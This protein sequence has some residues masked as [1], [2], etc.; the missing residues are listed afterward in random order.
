[1]ELLTWHFHLR[2]KA[3]LVFLVKFGNFKEWKLNLRGAIFFCRFP[4]SLLDVPDFPWC[5][6]QVSHSLSYKVLIQ[7]FGYSWDKSG[8]AGDLN[9][10]LCMAR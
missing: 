4:K 6:L 9:A 5:E 8:S 7:Y 2:Q 10:R 1:M 3:R